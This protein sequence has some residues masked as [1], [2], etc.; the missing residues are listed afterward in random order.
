MLCWLHHMVTL[1]RLESAAR[2]CGFDFEKLKQALTPDS[3]VGGEK[4]SLHFSRPPAQEAVEDDM[5][6]GS[7]SESCNLKCTLIVL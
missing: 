4:N 1:P 7:V 6:L 5:E 3:S 2:L